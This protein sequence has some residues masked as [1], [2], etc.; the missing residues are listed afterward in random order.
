MKIA[1]N[2]T[3]WR[4]FKR[5]IVFQFLPVV[6]FSVIM[7]VVCFFAI[8]SYTLQNV[9]RIVLSGGVS[10]EKILSDVDGVHFRIINSADIKAVL[11]DNECNMENEEFKKSLIKSQDFINTSINMSSYIDSIYVLNLNSNMV[12][13]NYQYDSVDNFFDRAWTLAYPKNLSK[14]ITIRINNG[15]TQ[16]LSFIYPFNQNGRNEGAIAINVKIGEFESIF[17]DIGNTYYMVDKEGNVL[18]G[19]G[20]GYTNSTE[21]ISLSEV[22]EQVDSEFHKGKIRSTY[23]FGNRGQILVIDIENSSY[24]QMNVIYQGVIVLYLIL[25]FGIIYILS[26]RYAEYYYQNIADVVNILS[27][28]DT[29]GDILNK[30]DEFSY[31]KSNIS[32]LIEKNSSNEI[33]L[34]K[35][36]LQLKQAQFNALQNQINPHFILNTLNMVNLLLIR[37]GDIH[38]EVL[39]INENVSKIMTRVLASEE[40]IIS[41]SQEVDCTKDYLEIERLKKNNSFDVKW[42]I[43]ENLNEEKTVKFILQ[44]IVENCITHGFSKCKDREKCINISIKKEKEN[45]VFVVQDNGC[46]MTKEKL[47][48]IRRQLEREDFPKSRNIA[49]L[50]VHQRIRIVYGSGFGLEIVQSDFYGTTIKMTIPCQG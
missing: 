28:Y 32:Q 11:M 45:I 29:E 10:A 8:R 9:N 39:K 19:A 42:N 20:E 1:K 34:S 16:Y 15:S 24:I 3:F 49:I 18:F 2:T 35:S 7:S 46:G 13:S 23:S 47:E 43:D 27:V 40:Y 38:H 30:L 26:K 37:K 44:P 31:I 22:E 5:N 17:E 6:V 36:I 25:V 41:V 48:E 33:Q 14:P 12:F 21:K 4:Y 50:N